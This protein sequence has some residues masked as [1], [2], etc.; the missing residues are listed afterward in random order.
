MS[1]SHH[2]CI[3][4]DLV[5]Y[6]TAMVEAT[7]S[8]NCVCGRVF[9]DLG[10]FMHHE[11]GCCKGRKRLASALEKVKQAYRSKK[12]R[13]PTNDTGIGLSSTSNA[14]RMHETQPPLPLPP[15]S[16]LPNSSISS[17]PQADV[18][19][20]CDTPLGHA[21]KSAS[22]LCSSSRKTFKSQINKFGLFRVYNTDALPSHDPDNP[23]SVINTCSWNV[24]SLS[25]GVSDEPSANT[26]LPYPN[27]SAMRLGDW[28]WNQG[29]HKSWESFKQLIDIVG[30]ASFSPAAVTHT[31]W[32]AID[33]QLGHNQFDGI[34]GTGCHQDQSELLGYRRLPS[35]LEEDHGRTCSSVTISVP[36]HS[37]VKDPGPKNYAVSGFY[38]RS[39]TSINAVHRVSKST[40]LG[41]EGSFAR[42]EKTLFG[43]W[44][45][46]NVGR[47][48]FRISVI[49]LK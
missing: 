39:L 36:F 26:Y 28:Y 25:P 9:S 13:V 10:T 15:T 27:E 37:R 41:M 12:A 17:A 33:D 3:L 38:H 46:L 35:W 49:H 7:F 34:R 20:S 2:R 18:T 24:V 30:D 6:C 1:H 40:E 21:E 48:E 5:C 44:L 11:K 19:S 47:Q 29:A 14:G 31:S 45:V 42:I 8:Q 22:P 4:P 23:Y 32:D 16:F 43:N